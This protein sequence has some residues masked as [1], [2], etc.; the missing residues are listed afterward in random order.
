MNE[1]NRL[2]MWAIGALAIVLL[3]ALVA[4]LGAA[5]LALGIVCGG[6]WNLASVWCLVQLL[7]AW[8]GPHPSRRRAIGWL[9]AKFPLLYAFVFL[10][11]RRPS[12]SLIGFGIGFTVVLVAAVSGLACSAQRMTMIRANGR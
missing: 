5:P 4:S 3:G 1:R 7:D 9:L 2:R 8:L 10:V 6:L 12:V 11:F